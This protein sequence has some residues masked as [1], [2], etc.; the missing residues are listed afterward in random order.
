MNGTDENR[1]L[2]ICQA[3]EH[4]MLIPWRRFSRYL[5]MRVRMPVLLIHLRQ[6]AAVPPESMSHI[7]Q[8]LGTEDKEMLR[9]EG[10]DHAIVRDPERAEAFEAIAA[11]LEWVAGSG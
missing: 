4:A 6:D 2:A 1:T 7:Y 5:Q 3:T 8:A 11:F 9:L 10:F